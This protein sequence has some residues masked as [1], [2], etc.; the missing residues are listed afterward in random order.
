MAKGIKRTCAVSHKKK[1]IT[2]VEVKVEISKHKSPP[3]STSP[4]VLKKKRDDCGVDN[5]LALLSAQKKKKKCDLLYTVGDSSVNLTFRTELDNFTWMIPQISKEI[6]SNFSC[7]YRQR[8]TVDRRS[9]RNLIDMT[10]NNDTGISTDRDVMLVDYSRC[11]AEDY[12]QCDIGETL[13]VLVPLF[14]EVENITPWSELFGGATKRVDITFTKQSYAGFVATVVTNP[15]LS[16]VTS[17]IHITDYIAGFGNHN[18]GCNLSFG[19][20]L[21]FLLPWK[22][23]MDGM[24][25]GIHVWKKGNTH[26]HVFAN[27]RARIKTTRGIQALT[28]CLFVYK[29]ISEKCTHTSPINW[30]D[31]T[32]DI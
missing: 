3:L 6:N 25:G 12:M 5:R 21:I 28:N 16:K 11:Y 23:V 19:P 30:H 13:L 26:R 2:A 10:I 20:E 24:I 7:K 4:I 22:L 15:S 27:Y 17:G 32:I 9:S 8:A 1:K 31:V 18:Y 29:N 14:D